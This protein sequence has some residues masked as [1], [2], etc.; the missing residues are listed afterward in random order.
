[1]ATTAVAFGLYHFCLGKRARAAD[2]TVFGAALGV[3]A[4]RFGLP[5]AMLMHSIHNSSSVPLGETAETLPTWR[6]RRIAY[7][8]ALAAAGVCGTAMSAPFEP[9][10]ADFQYGD[11]RAAGVASGSA[12][13]IGWPG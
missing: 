12:A 3:V 7:V 1:V 5:A 8:A 11:N 2:T 13:E 9:V 6:Q 4:L 10:D